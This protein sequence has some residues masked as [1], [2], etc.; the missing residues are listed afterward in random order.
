MSAESPTASGAANGSAFVWVKD[1]PKPKTQDWYWWRAWPEA[2]EKVFEVYRTER[3][4]IESWVLCHP[5]GEMEISMALKR[6]PNSEWSSTPIQRPNAPGE[7]PPTD[8]V[9]TRPEA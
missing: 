2:V 1:H 4:G 8:G 7:R 5:Y 6:W 9:R 3:F